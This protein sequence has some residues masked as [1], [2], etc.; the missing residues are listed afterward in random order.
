MSCQSFEDEFSHEVARLLFRV[1]GDPSKLEWG[2]R[3]VIAVDEVKLKLK[4]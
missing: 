4:N 1:K 3:R 2:R